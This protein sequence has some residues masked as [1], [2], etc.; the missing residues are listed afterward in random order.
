[1][2]PAPS[3]L[4]PVRGQVDFVDVSFSYKPDEPVLEAG[5]AACRTPGQRIA[6]VGETGA[7]K[8]TVIRLLAR[9]FDVTGGAG[10]GGRHR[11]AHVTVASLRSQMGIVLQ[12]TY[13][14]GAPR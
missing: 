10:A 8:S 13:L 5:D 11:H 12:D 7:G 1:M 9:F 2:R 6:L 3:I 14:F 4:P